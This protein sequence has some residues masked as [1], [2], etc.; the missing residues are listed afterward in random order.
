METTAKLVSQLEKQRR[1]VDVE[2]FDLTVR[3]LVRMAASKELIRAP[4][5][6]RKFRWDERDESRL[7]ES[8]LL[9]LPVPSV[10]VA[11]NEN[12]TWELV[13]GL[14]RISTLLHFLAKTVPDNVQETLSSIDKIAPLTLSHELEVLTAFRGYNFE[15]LPISVQL[16]LTKRAIRVTALSDKSDR[17]VRFEL[18]ERLNRG[19]VALTAQEV[20]A[21]IFHG[22]FSQLLRELAE[23]ADFKALLKLQKG[24]ES[25][26]TREEQVLKFFAYLNHRD[27]FDGAVSDFLTDYME[28]VES[29]FDVAA[30]RAL[31]EKVVRAIR[32][33]HPSAILRPKYH[34]TPLNQF[35]AILVAAGELIQSG[36][37]LKK[38]A[39]GWLADS[40]LVLYSTKGTNTV[41][42]LTNRI[43]R[44]KELLSGA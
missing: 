33:I 44:A 38:P 29:S 19:G 3:E 14:Q 12:G 36:K 8:L 21:C 1:R 40:E 20:R 15:S 37:T 26:G 11:T 9:G 28:A 39:K 10:F 5:Y 4:V 18:F 42:A 32:K 31:F 25:D 2:H 30:G 34:S 35:E 23:D 43:R 17:K 13:D 6:Q 27:D 24:Y 22:K 7:I 16:T 41:G